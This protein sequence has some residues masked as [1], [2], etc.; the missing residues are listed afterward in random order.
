MN[1]KSPSHEHFRIL[2]QK[3]AEKPFQ[4]S[5]WVSK[6]AKQ[7]D[8]QT[9]NVM[10]RVEFDDQLFNWHFDDV[11]DGDR[12]RL[13]QFFES[14]GGPPGTIDVSKFLAKLEMIYY[15]KGFPDQSKH[16]VSEPT[17]STVNWQETAAL[18][19]DSRRAMSITN[20]QLVTF[21]DRIA[22]RFFLKRKRITKEV[23][24]KRLGLN[25]RE[26]I[27]IKQL[28]IVL[29]EHEFQE[30]LLIK[31]FD[32][33]EP[34]DG[35]I[36]ADNM[37]RKLNDCY[38]R[39]HSLKVDPSQRSQT[40][41]A[42]ISQHRERAAPEIDRRSHSGK[43]KQMLKYKRMIAEKFWGVGC[44]WNKVLGSEVL[45][46]DRECFKVFLHNWHFY[47]SAE[48][49]EELWQ[50]YSEGKEFI[51]RKHFAELLKRTLENNLSSRTSL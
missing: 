17:D 34:I 46:I 30:D 11:T 36:T 48:E 12:E 33:F 15:Q 47:I 41:V 32:F 2:L 6:T 16:F 26:R 8:S 31:I 9:S 10:T 51:D 44:D 38:F 20:E 42:F 28:Q 3:M 24:F 23:L 27:S 43:R 39:R 49:E 40:S 45:T 19:D 18:F 50:D 35:K 5:S 21:V 13:F 22:E 4:K 14:E 25:E 29:E 7:V 37:I 1:T